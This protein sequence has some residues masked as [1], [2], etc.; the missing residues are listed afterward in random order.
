VADFDE[1]SVEQER[2][3]RQQE[4][5]KA[6]LSRGASGG[7]INAYT[8]QN[9]MEQS[10]KDRAALAQRYQAGLAE[11]VKRIAALRQGREAI[12]AP[13]DE[14]G[15]GPGAPA[16]PGD[17]RAA[18]Q[19][20]M[21]SQYA[22]V[23]RVGDLEYGHLKKADEPYTLKPGEIRRTPGQPDSTNPNAPPG[24]ELR[25]ELAAQADKTRRDLATQADETR[26]QIAAAA[27]AQRA[28]KNT[29]K[30]P[31]P[32]LKLQQ[33]ELDA[34]GTASSI[35]A[36]LGGIA[37][38]I[39]DGKLDLSPTNNLVGSARNIIGISNENSRN[40]ASFK[41]T[42][43]KL[44]NDSLRL[45]KGV[46]TEGDAQRAWNELVANIND[47]GVVKQRLAEIQKINERA[48]NLRKMN[49]DSI[50]G[51]FGLDPMDTGGYEKQPAAVGKGGKGIPRIASDAEFNALPS[52]AEFFGPDGKKRRKP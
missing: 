49:V 48:V 11:E 2:I 16:Q 32:A 21:L 8:G 17:P 41:S 29:P 34:I 24:D 12:E 45:N 47:K 22:P 10:D 46:Q 6:L 38:Q 40:L 1:F 20:A 9:M 33:E 30:L 25:R 23:R 5:A 37:K 31:T 36:D 52:G 50:R 19:A 4:I 43:E 26:R 15:G 51:N 44:R 35:N 13:A 27:E 42:L 7:L 14:L 18:V 39:D 3:A 28:Q